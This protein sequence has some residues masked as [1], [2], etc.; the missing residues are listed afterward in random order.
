RPYADDERSLLRHALAEAGTLTDRT[1][2][3]GVIG[4]AEMLTTRTHAE[5]VELLLTANNIAPSSIAVVGFHGQTVIHRPER[6]FTVQVGDGP[7]LAKRLGIAVAYDFRAADIAA[8]G[9]GAP[10]VPVFHRAIVDGGPDPIACDAGP[11]NALIDDF[12]RARTG[13]PYDDNGDVAAGG[14]PDEAF[15]AQVLE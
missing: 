15:I 9:Q 6:R 8:G 5:T 3:P 1:A 7:A 12:M 13:A 10:L 14:K 11:G 2:R 4:A